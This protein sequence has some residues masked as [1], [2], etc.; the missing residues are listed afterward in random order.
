MKIYYN[1]VLKQLS[2]N[3]RNQSTL[4]EILLWKRLRARQICG[5]QFARQKPIKDFIVD[6]YCSKLQ[7]VV[8]IDGSSH[9]SE[10]AYQ[11]DL[12][13]QNELESIG[14]KFLRFEDRDV[15]QR[16][17]DVVRTIENWITNNT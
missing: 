13:R 5:Y 14:L 7:L 6:F 12:R 8:E 4:S 2:R 9:Y 11:K 15:K 17:D 10:E 3:L 16:L 1:P